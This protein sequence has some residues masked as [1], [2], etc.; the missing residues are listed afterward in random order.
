MGQSSKK[1]PVRALFAVL[2]DFVDKVKVLIL[3]VP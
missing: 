1:I 2:E 3:F